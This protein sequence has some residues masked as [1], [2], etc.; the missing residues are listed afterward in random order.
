MGFQKQNYRNIIS[1][2]LNKSTLDYFVGYLYFVKFV[3]KKRL[4]T[5]MFLKIIEQSL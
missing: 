2:Y 1:V 4:K 5:E 3:A